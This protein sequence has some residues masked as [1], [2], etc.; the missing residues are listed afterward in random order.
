MLFLHK[1]TIVLTESSSSY[2]Q[3]FLHYTSEKIDFASNSKCS[4]QL[5]AKIKTPNEN[6]KYFSIQTVI[7]DCSSLN[8][9][10]TV[11]IKAIDQ[12]RKTK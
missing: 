11:G 1:F 2:F 6:E 4:T 8:C 5:N 12:V 3:V 9:I 7:L 10:D